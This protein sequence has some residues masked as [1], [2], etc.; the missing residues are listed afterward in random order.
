MMEMIEKMQ[1]LVL[2]GVSESLKVEE[3]AI[4]QLKTSEALVRVEAAALNRRDWWIQQG[5]YAGLKFP[6][7]LG[8][9]G[10]G[11]VTQVADEAREGHWLG[12][13]VMIHPALHWLE[14]TAVQ[15]DSFRILGLPDDGTLA[16][17]V[18]VPTAHLFKKPNY[19]S[20]E[21]AAAIPLAG[22]TAYRALFTKARVQKG[23][24][25]LV[26]GIG[27]G[28]ATFAMLWAAHAGAEVYVTSGDPHKLNKI[29]NL[30]H[31]KGGVNYKDTDWADQLKEMAGGFDVIIDGALGEGFAPFLDLANPGGRI[32]FY[33]GTSGNIPELNGRKIFW[34]QLQILGTTMGSAAEFAQMLAFAEQHQIRPIIDEVFPW[35]EGQKALHRMTDSGQLGK[36]VLRF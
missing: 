15:P 9:D 33:G 30:G 21:E 1:A 8:S 14:N 28:V 26:T 31:T 18:R 25:V 5:K 12:Q 22:L 2:N 29:Q 4:P 16:E 3:V 32:V 23:E 19:L 13:R 36:L 27:G 24:K 10:V 20:L 6:I 17:Y 11:V 34:K 35:T 7:V